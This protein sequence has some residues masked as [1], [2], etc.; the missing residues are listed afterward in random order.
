MPTH[1]STYKDHLVSCHI[2]RLDCGRFGVQVAVVS[3]VGDKTRTQRFIDL[4]EAYA[5][6][7]EAQERGVAAGIDWVDTNAHIVDR[8]FYVDRLLKHR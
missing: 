8:G 4:R 7:G 6:E 5:T 1:R 3:M 2:A